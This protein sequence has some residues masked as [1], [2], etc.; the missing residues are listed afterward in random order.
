MTLLEIIDHADRENFRFVEIRSNF[1]EFGDRTPLDRKER[2]EVSP[3]ELQALQ[4]ELLRLTK[5][6]DSHKADV[7]VGSEKP[8]RF[9][10]SGSF[11]Q[12]FIELG[13][14]RIAVRYVIDNRRLEMWNIYPWYRNLEE[15]DS[16]ERDLRLRCREWDHFTDSSRDE[17]QAYIGSLVLIHD[18]AEVDLAG[19]IATHRIARRAG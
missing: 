7:S 2:R 15:F 16:W 6:E 17:R 19:Y 5:F 11:N 4:S 10:T 1:V 14:R 3:G 13:S 9:S 18:L 12:G 8:G